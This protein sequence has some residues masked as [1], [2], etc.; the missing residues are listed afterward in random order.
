M[1]FSNV[2][3]IIFLALLGS[4]CDKDNGPKFNVYPLPVWTV[5][6]PE[7]FPNSFTAIVN[8]PKNMN[9]LAQDTDLVAAFIDDECRGIGNLVQSED[10]KRRAYIITVR[11]SSTEN[12]NIV[13]KYYST[14]TSYLYQAATT[15]AFEID[16]TYGT[17]DTPITLDLK[18]I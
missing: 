10:K 18:N 3:F 1:K 15:I 12:R 13:F 7:I 14:R 16:G 5:Q 2:I 9:L 8:L 6:S 4:G 17:Y 11:G